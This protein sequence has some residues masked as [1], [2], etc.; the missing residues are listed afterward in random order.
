M[1]SSKQSSLVGDIFGGLTAGV[2]AL[3]LALAFG[4]T[5][6]LPPDIAAVAGL[7]GAIAVGI[8]A[9]L[10]GGTATQIS[11]PTG[12]MTVVAATVIASAKA[13]GADIDLGFIFGTFTLA[14]I[15]LIVMGIAKVGVFIRY[16]PHPVVSGFMSGIGVIILF[17]QIFP[18]LGHASPASPLAVLQQ[19]TEPFSSPNLAALGVTALTVAI[20]YATPRVTKTVPGPLAAL[21]IVTS[22]VGL[23]GIDVAV[24]GAIPTGFP[25][26]HL[27]IPDFETFTRMVPAALSL[28]ALGAIDSLLTSVVADNITRTQHDPNRELVGQG[29]GNVVSGLIGGLPGAGATMRTVVNVQSGGTTRRSGIIHGA[30][31]LAVLL[32]LGPL[33][34]QVPKPVLA[35]IL[36]TVGIGIIDYKGLRQLSRMPRPDAIVLVGVL[37]A[38]VFVDLLWAVAVGVMFSGMAFIQRMSAM[39]NERSL[40]VPLHESA[41]GKFENQIEPELGE[42][43]YVKELDG[44][45]F[46]GVATQ[47]VGLSERI[48]ADVDSV[49]IRMDRVSY[50]DQSGLVALDDAISRLREKDIVVALAGVAEQPRN[51]LELLHVIPE[52]VP[53]SLVFP[54]FDSASAAAIATVR[55]NLSHRSAQL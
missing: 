34:A 46:F 43:I 6:G 54:D 13:Q 33:A 10:F 42:K 5:S 32:G 52:L 39:I 23:V 31:L 30:L 37:L 44:P 17:L 1:S 35:G 14:G 18:S 38:T 15:F 45:L 49:I 3:P 20:I 25:E 16:I 40:V 26:L 41:N 48:S 27:D 8:L 22:L 53:S 19:V 24:I 11:G 50:I 29:I 47:L 36:I 21:I 7:Y 28:A 2:V 4:I 12:P 51:L 9:A 55:E